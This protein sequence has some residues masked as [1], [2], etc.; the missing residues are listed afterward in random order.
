MSKG[1][2]ISGA[3]LPVRRKFEPVMKRAR[4]GTPGFSADT[5]L[6]FAGELNSSIA[7]RMDRAQD[8]YDGSALPLTERY[9]ASKLKKLGS[10]VRDLRWTGRTRRGMRPLSASQNVAIIGFSDP[11]AMNRIQINNRRVRQYGVSPVNR[12]HLYNVV[13]Q[14]LERP[15]AIET[16]VG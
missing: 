12:Q 3:N 7:G 16:K 14:S 10:A 15:V 8:V 2:P 6:R 1:L 5:M 13:H 11:V 9:A 4:V